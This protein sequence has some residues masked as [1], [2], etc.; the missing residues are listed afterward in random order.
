VGAA[1]ALFVLFAAGACGGS[2]S[3]NGAGA[4]PSSD[5]TSGST[6]VSGQLR[7]FA[8]AD[9][10]ESPVFDPFV[11]A[12]PDLSVK[13]SDIAGDE[14]AVAKLKAGFQADVINTCAGPI[15]EEIANGSL[16]PIDTSRI[17]D[18]NKI[19]PFFKGIKGVQVHG[20]TYM[21]PLVGGAYGLVY[22][23]S[24]FD[25]PPTSWMDLFTTDKRVTE[26][27]DPL[28]NIIAAG[29]ALG[30]FPP[31]NMD[32]SQL[33]QVKQL[34]ISQKQHVVTYYQG[35]ALNNLWANGEVDITPTDLT[36]VNQL[37]GND[38]AFAPMDP[39]L[40]WTCGYSVGA[41]AQ[42]LDA[43][44]AFMNYALSP[45]VQKIQAEKFSYLVSNKE[46]VKAL[47]PS[48]LEKTGQKDLSKYHSAATFGTPKDNAA[49]TQ[50]WQDVKSG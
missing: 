24:V 20:K 5:D 14:A 9:A 7:I 37:K 48:V 3:S 36:L 29:L 33:A 23:P 4:P 30:F 25:T 45:L 12:N 16:Q 21:L 18:W 44:Y 40:A 35:A 26:P 2:S 46:S 49:W 41:H 31:Q 27:D 39:P 13:K 6:A 22:R 50:L 8:Y 15:D 38:V 47:S 43:V 28:T 34:L 42:N 11:K 10:F 32:A 1:T 19:Y 17:T